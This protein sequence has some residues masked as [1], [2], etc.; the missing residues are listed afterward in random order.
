MEGLFHKIVKGQLEKKQKRIL[1]ITYGIAFDS[2]I[3]NRDRAGQ[4]GSADFKDIPNS[5]RI[6]Q[7]CGLLNA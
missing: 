6:L 2:L 4:A 3:R 1:T 7:R 5:K